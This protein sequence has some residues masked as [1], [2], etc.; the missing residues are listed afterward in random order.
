[1]HDQSN[2]MG[3]HVIMHTTAVILYYHAAA[4]EAVFTYRQTCSYHGCT[5]WILIAIKLIIN[6]AY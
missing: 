1:M 6:T 5:T 4:A 3:Q 2:Y